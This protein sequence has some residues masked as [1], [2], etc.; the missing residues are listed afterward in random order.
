MKE[1]TY[2]D[3]RLDTVREGEAYTKIHKTV[4]EPP[5]KEA[6]TPTLKKTQKPKNPPKKNH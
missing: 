4:F 5:K 3:T 6:T 1:K 2:L